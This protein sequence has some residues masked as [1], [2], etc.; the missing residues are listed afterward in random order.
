MTRILSLVFLLLA[1]AD[2][3]IVQKTIALD[4]PDEDES[5][6]TEEA[7][8]GRV[9][10][11]S[12]EESEHESEHADTAEEA[13]EEVSERLSEE[14]S[15][16]RSEEH[17]EE[18]GAIDTPSEYV[19][20]GVK[21][22]VKEDEEWIHE[23]E[24]LGEEAIA[25]H[26]NVPIGVAIIAALFLGAVVAEQKKKGRLAWLPESA[27]TIFVGVC[28]GVWM[29]AVLGRIPFF[30]DE[31]TFNETC[32][33]LLNLLLLP[34]LM[35]EAG[36]STK[37][38]DFASQFNYI[39]LF[40]IFGS[41]ISF[42]TVG[43]LIYQTGQWGLHSVKMPR[44]AFAYASLIAATDPVA[45]L[46]VYTE[47]KVD[48][49]LNILVFGDSIFN[50]AVAIVLF[51][52]LNNDSI[53]GTVDSRPSLKELTWKISA[54]IC[55]IFGGSLLVGLLVGAVF[56]LTLRFLHMRN[57]PR[58]EVLSLVA[59]AFI[60]F[61]L[62]EA[63]EMSG[64]IATM[65]CSILIG[66][67]G[68]VHLTGIGA[69]MGTY[70]L[71]QLAR[72]MDTSVFLLVGF[73]S[74][75]LGYK[76]LLFGAW[77]M[78]FCLIGRAASVFPVAKLS[79][80]IK[81]KTGRGAQIPGNAMFM[82]WHAA[83]RG[84]ISLTLSMQLGGWVDNLDGAGTRHIM[85]TGTYLLII[86]FLFVFGGSTEYSLEKLKVPMGVSSSDKLYNEEL[87]TSQKNFLNKL[88]SKFL[89]PILVGSM[90]AMT[91]AKRDLQDMDV[92]DVLDSLGKK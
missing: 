38:K 45:T 17:S 27:V 12:E 4:N 35:F 54:G 90:D 58:L 49:L 14:Q 86:V 62:A 24:E 77:A 72:L 71:Q 44:T 25:K 15:E 52:V 74:V 51:K 1:F 53:M 60:C 28:L 46:A 70:F 47:L 91:D 92:E 61:S 8:D 40:A 3:S 10:F 76:G 29:K 65:F 36:W 81:R 19:R 43:C 84:A 59:L 63:I 31:E 41:L 23:H 6:Q 20:E 13:S 78:L 57:D 11:A 42:L 55:E 80:V 68:R 22:V 2:G 37:Y 75:N 64:I 66:L 26:M 5:Y 85:Q 34:I 82:M 21:E 7:N 83:L 88:D 67:Y 48:P 73:C 56:L 50:D 30:R 87:S 16:E 32:A 18:S 33:T 9:N 89:T 39:M 69:M 79:N